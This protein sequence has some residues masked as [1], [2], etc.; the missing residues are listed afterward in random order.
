MLFP[1]GSDN[2]DENKEK[3]VI[4]E[5][6]G[7]SSAR[8]AAQRGA[9]GERPVCHC[10][11]CGGLGLLPPAPTDAPRMCMNNDRRAL[12]FLRQHP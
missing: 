5:R 7:I 8:S 4:K 10:V 11:M 9:P 1:H 12:C 2:P 3:E 6:R